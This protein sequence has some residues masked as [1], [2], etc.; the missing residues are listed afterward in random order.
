MTVSLVDRLFGPSIWK[1]R[2]QRETKHV[3][4]SILSVF[5][6]EMQKT[7]APFSVAG[8]RYMPDPSSNRNTV[9]GAMTAKGAIGM[10]NQRGL[11]DLKV[12]DICCGVGVVGLTLFSEFKESGIVKEVVLSDINI[13]NI[14]T[15]KRALADNGLD[16]LT[17]SQIR[18][19]LS[20]GLSHIPKEEKFDII[21]SNPPH[22]FAQESTEQLVSTPRLGT[23]DVEWAFHKSFYHECHHYLTA[24]GEVWF[25]ENSVKATEGDFLPFVQANANLEYVEKVPE[26][27]DARFFWMITRLSRSTS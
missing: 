16:P 9:E 18:H 10:I 1:R 25:L 4:A 19:Y 2:A 5:G 27:L 26:P 13:F 22:I 15:L 6:Y 8:V 7:K 12:L 3:A 24:R 23:Y 21:V 14:H 20:D 17:P 11:G